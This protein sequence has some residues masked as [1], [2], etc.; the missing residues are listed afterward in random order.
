[1]KLTK[2]NYWKIS[3]ITKKYFDKMNDKMA[4]KVLTTP[5]IGEKLK[6]KKL[7]K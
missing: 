6:I 3:K 5:W 7:K 1:M 4:L 2:Q